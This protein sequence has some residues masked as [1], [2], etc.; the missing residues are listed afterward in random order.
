MEH[1]EEAPGDQIEDAPFVGRELR[2]VVLDVGRDD[3]VVV[4]DARVID[5]AA[6][7]ELPE[8]EHVARGV[9]VLGDRDERLGP[10][11][12]LR[13]EIAG[14][15]A[16]RGSRIRD[17]LLAL[18]E[19]LRRLERAARGEA[20][21]AVRVALERGEV[22][23]ERRPL[24]L[25]LPLDRL[26]LAVLAGDALDDLV[27]ACAFLDPRLVALEPEAVVRRLEGGAD[28]PVRLGDEDL[29]LAL[30][31]HDHRERRGLDAPERDDAAD[32]RAAADR[33]GAGRVH[34]DE[35]VGLG[36]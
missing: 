36:A 35:P 4:V 18:V 34:A 25:L 19:R 10:G 27:G 7:R 22:V 2:H 12:E 28:E 8:G 15:E 9:G 23:E 16:R 24:G 20:E 6:E 3:R 13:H 1:G 21:A 14:E 5:D 31:L 11:L 32:P 17:R 33:C 30:A 29:D 26:D